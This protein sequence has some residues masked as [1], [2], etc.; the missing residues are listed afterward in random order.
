MAQI[1][2]K[3]GKY[4]NSNITIQVG[5]KDT[6]DLVDVIKLLINKLD[7]VVSPED[8]LIEY[9]N[10]INRLTKLKQDKEDIIRFIEMMEEETL[11]R[12]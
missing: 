2:N 7:E 11:T 3:K 9:H 12:D 10:L 8:A 4:M 6:G 1:N 5:L